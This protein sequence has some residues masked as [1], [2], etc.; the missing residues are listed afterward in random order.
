MNKTILILG[1][2]GRFG[3]HAQAAFLHAGWTVT[4]FDR[5][6]DNL[7]ASMAQADVVLMAQNPPGYHL[8]QEQLVDLHERV[9]KAAARAGVTV[10]IP[11]NVYVYGP[12]APFGWTPNTPHGAKNPLGRLRIAAEAAYRAAG[13]RTIILRCGDFIDTEKTGNWF[14]NY[15]ARDVQKGVL[16]YPGDPEAPHTWAFLPDAA[17]AAVALADI[18]DQLTDFEDVPFPGFTLSG[19]EMAESVSRVMRRPVKVRPFAWGIL[20]VMSP[21]M[22]MLR[23]VFEMRYLWSLPHRL[24]GG[25]LA[26]LAPGFEPTPVGEALRTALAHQTAPGRAAA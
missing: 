4:P 11:G 19:V 8:W 5:A 14:E 9:A 20:R 24:D 26:E 22:P 17:R 12:D 3:R 1:A 2:S 21:F 10:I 15:I 16:R 7:D 6:R 25:R 23:G 18:R 13:A